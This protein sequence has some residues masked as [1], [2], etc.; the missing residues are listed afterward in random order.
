[1]SELFSHHPP[2]ARWAHILLRVF[3]GALLAQHGAQK[4]F[5]IFGGF[6]SPGATAP[7][8]TLPW[9]AGVIELVGGLLVVLGLFTRPAAF[10][11]AGEMAVAYFTSHFPQ[12][13]WPIENHGELAV[14][15]CFVFLYF[16]ATG[17]GAMSLDWIRTRQNPKQGMST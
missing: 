1:M 12:S 4:L 16:S 2:Y 5:G 3:A 17:A 8:G 14:L 9:F 6:M 7:M 10:I 11:V 13:F 15:F